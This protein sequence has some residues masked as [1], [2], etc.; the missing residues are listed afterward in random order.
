MIFIDL[1]AP[2]E[3]IFSS[4]L[5]EKSAGISLELSMSS[6]SSYDRSASSR[7]NANSGSNYIRDD[8]HGGFDYKDFKEGVGKST[9]SSSGIRLNKHYLRALGFFEQSRS[10]RGATFN[11]SFLESPPYSEEVCESLVFRCNFCGRR[12]HNGQALGGHQNA[13]RQERD[14]ERIALRSHVFLRHRAS[15]RT[16]TSTDVSKIQGVFSDKAISRTGPAYSLVQKSYRCVDTT[17]S[18]SGLRQCRFGHWTAKPKISTHFNGLNNE[19]NL[20]F[21]G[22]MPSDEN[23]R[24]HWPGSAKDLKETTCI[25]GLRTNTNRSAEETS[26]NGGLNNE[27]ISVL[28][29]SL[30]L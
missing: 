25:Q 27:D 26:G 4:A 12:F 8:R 24:F 23:A 7:V 10:R 16:G 14:P 20:E 11:K 17:G 3:T 15:N 30:R 21:K 18:A 9:F 29:L 5:A 19:M 1:E 22:C 13:H 28:D 6:S 2:K